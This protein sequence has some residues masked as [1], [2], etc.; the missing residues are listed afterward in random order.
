LPIVAVF[1]YEI[2]PMGLLGELAEVK[3]EDVKIDSEVASGPDPTR[4]VAADRVGLGAVFCVAVAASLGVWPW[5]GVS[6]FADEGATVYSAHLSWSNLWAQSQH[7]DLVLLPYYVLIHYW[8]MVS[9]NIAWVRALSLLAFFGTIVTIGW[10]GIRIA[11]RWCGIIA[12]VLTATSTL[13]VEKSLNARPYELSS[14]LVV[15]CAVSLFKWLEDSRAR[16]L[17]AFSVLAVL[18]TAMQLF[19]LLAPASML[20]CVLL[21]RPELIAQRLR[22]LRAPVALLAIVSCA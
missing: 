14:F 20:V 12:S 11:D 18:A 21:V 8:Q 3:V 17:W 22:V 2:H 19:S 15:L 10:I 6:M 9:G 4:P 7:V 13:L 5:L 1:Q 16:R